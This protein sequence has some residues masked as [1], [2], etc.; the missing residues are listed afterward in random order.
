MVAA[1]IAVETGL[2]A[3]STVG[4]HTAFAR[5]IASERRTA[6]RRPER[7]VQLAPSVVPFPAADRRTVDRASP[8]AVVG[9]SAEVASEVRTC[10]SS[11][12]AAVRASLW[13][14][15]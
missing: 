9:T 6:L 14:G 12:S 8:L 3:N 11:D 13:R 1:S 7:I 5:H 4:H 15:H 2:A 10:R